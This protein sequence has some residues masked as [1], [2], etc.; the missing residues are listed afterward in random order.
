VPKTLV[1]YSGSG[2]STTIYNNFPS[3]LTAEVIDQYG[4]PLAGVTVNFSLPVNSTGPQF[5]DGS[6]ANQAVTDSSGLARSIAIRAGV[7][8]GTVTAMAS[9]ANPVGP[10][11]FTLTTNL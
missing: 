3:P 10:A 5:V 9:V 1:A 6:Y 7:A 2:Q 11:Y 8:V 4:N